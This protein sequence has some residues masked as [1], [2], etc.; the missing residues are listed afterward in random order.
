M[1]VCNPRMEQ[2]S[3]R[4]RSDVRACK[5]CTARLEA[6]KQDERVSL[7]VLVKRHRNS[8]PHC[9][10]KRYLESLRLP[11]QGWHRTRDERFPFEWEYPKRPEYTAAM[12]S[13]DASQGVFPAPSP[14]G[15][16]IISAELGYPE[17]AMV[18]PIEVAA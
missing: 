18:L 1:A 4:S 11:S 13:R 15:E 7:A 10:E 16:G 8:R 6:P 3:T 14:W 12:R 2:S 5:S 17:H 9:S